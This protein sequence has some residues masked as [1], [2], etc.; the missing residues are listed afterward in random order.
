MLKYIALLTDG[1]AEDLQPDDGCVCVRLRVEAD[2]A[3]DQARRQPYC[4]RRTV[5]M[6]PYHLTVSRVYLPKSLSVFT[7]CLLCDK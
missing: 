5:N 3:R 4:V 1:A 2:G 7:W 6:V